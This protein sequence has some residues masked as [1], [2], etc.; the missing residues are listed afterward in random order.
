[1]GALL[2]F[3]SAAWRVRV[4]GVAAAVLAL[5]LAGPLAEF[6]HYY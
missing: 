6:V 5:A 3:C 4:S 2:E 1:M